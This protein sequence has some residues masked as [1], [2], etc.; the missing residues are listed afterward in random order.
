MIG[1]I[2]DVVQDVVVWQLEAVRHA[3]DTKSEVTTQRGGSAAN[4]AAFAAP[5][6]PTRFI[7]CVGDDLGGWVLTQELQ[8]RGVDVRLQVRGPTGTIVVLIDRSGERL[9]FPS[10]GACTMLE[11]IDPSWLD[12]LEILHITAYSFD[13]GSTPQTVRDALAEHRRRGG[14][15]SM[16][17]SSI[18]MIEH[19]GLPTFLELMDECRPDLISANSDESRHLGLCDADTP[20]HNL[21]RFGAAVLLARQGKDATNVFRGGRHLA[22]VPV[23]PVEEVRD[24]TGA[25]DAFNAGFLASYLTGGGNLVESCLAGHALSA[26]VLQCPGASE[27]PLV[28]GTSDSSTSSASASG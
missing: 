6:Y 5:R 22:T 17:V 23:A 24:L 11:A 16:D 26:L 13:G 9:M 7:G 15:V 12:D 28:A 14:K 3:T 20:G 1:V 21:A 10:R 2:G 25:G 4:V 27:P 8:Q 19:F 18:G